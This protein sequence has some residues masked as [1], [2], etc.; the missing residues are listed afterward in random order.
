MSRYCV[1]VTNFHSYD[2]VNKFIQLC[3]K[4]VEAFE[5]VSTKICL[6]TTKKIKKDLRKNCI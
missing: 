2:N 3:K 4:V 5:L 6:F 1:S